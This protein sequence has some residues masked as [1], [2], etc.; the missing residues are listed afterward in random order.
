MRSLHHARELFR[1]PSHFNHRQLLLILLHSTPSWR[2]AKVSGSVVLIGYKFCTAK[3]PN[4]GGWDGVLAFPGVSHGTPLSRAGMISDLVF[5][6]L[7]HVCDVKSSSIEMLPF[8]GMGTIPAL[9]RGSS[10]AEGWAVE[11]D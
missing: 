3:G 5:Y 6:Y 2:Q 10:L 1:P 11:E 8:H 9:L 7:L 4:T